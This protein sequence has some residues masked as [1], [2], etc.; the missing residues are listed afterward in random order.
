MLRSLARTARLVAAASLLAGSWLA[1][2]P[3]PASAGMIYQTVN[4]KA[5][6]GYLALPK[7][8]GTHPGVIVIHEWWGLNDWVKEQADSLAAQ[9]YVALAVDLYKGKVANDQE[10]AHQYMSGLAEDAAIA[11]LRRGATFLRSRDDV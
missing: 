7:G 4:K 3:A 6:M 1:F 2:A 8:K 10:T 5:L 11:T 9:G